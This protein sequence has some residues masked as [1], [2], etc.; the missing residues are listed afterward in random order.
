[1]SIAAAGADGS[2]ATGL[3]KALQQIIE[4]VHTAE[5][6]N[7]HRSRSPVNLVTD[8]AGGLSSDTVTAL[9][10]RLLDVE[11]EQKG[12]VVVYIEDQLPTATDLVEY[13]ETRFRAWRI[14]KAT[15]M[16]QQLARLQNDPRMKT[17]ILILIVAKS[18]HAQIRVGEALS[19]K[20]PARRIQE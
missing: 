13:T 12:M 3:Q 17:G 2:Y 18:G 10:F 6:P 5:K 9:Q 20:L 11:R 4:G 15:K 16:E 19:A 14:D 1:N 7:A 8:N